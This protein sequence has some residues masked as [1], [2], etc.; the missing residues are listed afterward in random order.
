[1]NNI[2]IFIELSKLLAIAVLTTGIVRLFKQP[3]IIGYILS[4]I[5]AGPV[6]FNV[7]SATNTLSAF[8]QIGV[9]LLLFFVGLNLNPKV[10]K[11]VGKVSLLT[12][13]GQVLFTTS[14]GFF[15]AKLAGFPTVTSLYVGI[16]LAFSSTI[17]I[18]K[19]LSDK[20]DLESL[21]GRISVGFLIVQDF[22]AIFALL[23]ISSIG[24]GENLA[25]MA[26]ETILKGV[27]G[28]FILYLLTKYFLPSLLRIIARSQEFL[29]LFSISWCFI[30]AS[31]FH[32]LN[33]SLEAGALMAGITLSMSPYH[34][35]I[36]SKLK[37]L[38]DF[39]LILFFIMLGSEMIFANIL[40][41]I[42]LIIGLALF[43]MIGNPIIVMTLMGLLG[44]TRR[45]SFLSGLTVAQISEFSFI[46]ITLGLS[47]GHVTQEI[48]SIITAVGLLT[49]AGSTYM[50]LYSN[51]LYVEL[52]PYLK[53][54]ERKGKKVDEHRHH[55]HDK[56]EIILFGYNRIGFDILESLK[57]I[58]KEFL[59]I[60]YDPETIKNLSKE[61]YSCKYGDANNLELLEE[62]NF[63]KAKMVISTIP[64][65]D[66]NM[67]LIKKVLEK[68]PK[69]VIA[70]VS[71]HIDEAE[72]LYEEGATYV[73]MP[74]FL[75]GRHF[76]TMIENNELSMS[77][78]LEEKIAHI[79][80]L[81]RR[82]TLGHKHPTHERK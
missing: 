20:K 12:G 38:R 22:I 45:N 26:L 59:I 67:L 30:V 39:F 55:S 37:P 50:I 54:F 27:G 16:G 17:V 15:I 35:E 9:A 82:K 60:D 63:K 24:N 52:S 14:I 81:R 48:L 25:S 44:Y 2:D 31:L 56:H 43:V 5:V 75:G 36:S 42:G 58:K 66:T 29:L 64:I 65:I 19:L 3:A 23:I 28:I 69:A 34:F 61:G 80:H 51:K 70:V 57:R 68:N 78:F 1:M 41:N 13:V 71:H 18:M 7:I 46:V 33:F 73:I 53:I 4:G 40:G 76:S 8:S 11:D 79:E 47:V 32:Y 74:H 72:K 77:K 6:L 10:I 21:Y 49:F 62:I